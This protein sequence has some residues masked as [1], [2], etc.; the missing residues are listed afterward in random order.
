[1]LD[2]IAQ[3]QRAK[4]VR[5]RFFSSQSPQSL[6]ELEEKRI[7]ALWDL[8]IFQDFLKK[9]GA[10]PIGLY[11]AIRDEASTALLVKHLSKLGY[12]LAYPRVTKEGELHFHRGSPEHPLIKSP[13]GLLEP[14]PTLPIVIPDL[15]IVPLLAFDEQ[16]GRMGYGKGYYDLYFARHSPIIKIG[17]AYGCQQ[18]DCLVTEAHDVP[19]DE[20]IYEN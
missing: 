15:C 6:L 4:A 20:V 16:K 7:A 12:S 14:E 10:G 8:R 17:W 19:L 18:V 3:R 2:K 13:L 11:N 5:G 1:M 9:K